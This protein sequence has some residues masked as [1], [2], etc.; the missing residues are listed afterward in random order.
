M[1]VPVP[2][3]RSHQAHTRGYSRV[4]SLTAPAWPLVAANV[5]YSPALRPF[6][7][8]PSPRKVASP[9]RY[10]ASGWTNN[11]AF[12]NQPTATAA[13]FLTPRPSRYLVLSGKHQLCAVLAVLFAT[14]VLCATS[15]T[16]LTLSLLPVSSL[17]FHLPACLALSPPLPPSP[18]SL[19]LASVYLYC[20]FFALFAFSGAQ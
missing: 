6:F 11:A 12:A 4:C 8:T 20:L 19:A 3:P 18:P 15:R 2:V 5:K 9:S 10:S 16:F 14:Y 1:P 17:P 13:S 7:A